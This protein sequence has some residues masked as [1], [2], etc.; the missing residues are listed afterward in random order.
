MKHTPENSRIILDCLRRIVQ[1]LRQSSSESER[2]FGLNG[3]QAWV[4]RAIADHQGASVNT[5]AALTFTHQS[6]VSEIVAK[7]EA[8]GMVSR[9][10]STED[11][12]KVELRLTE[13]G[14]R[15]VGQ[16]LRS[17]NEMLMAAVQGLPPE[18]A[19][20]L[21]MGLTTLADA[22]GVADKPARMFFE[23][24]DGR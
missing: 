21:A 5:I 8:K 14:A 12:R 3:A 9:T 13:D 7:L 1:A 19:A 10:R 20:Q 23:D 4:L 2:A 17:G 16:G 24:G 18:T 6:T 22:A 11:G 15:A